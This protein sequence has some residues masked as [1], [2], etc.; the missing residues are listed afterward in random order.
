MLPP[1]ILIG[2]KIR[3]GVMLKSIHRGTYF[4]SESIPQRLKFPWNNRGTL[5]SQGGVPGS[6]RGTLLPEQKLFAFSLKVSGRRRGTLLSEWKLNA[7]CRN[8]NYVLSVGI[9][10]TYF[11]SEFQLLTFLL[12]LDLKL[13]TSQQW[14]CQ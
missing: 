1:L 4:R 3:K 6:H 8:S 7:F 2:E 12:L 10:I 14:L 5:R 13:T 11:Q 9:P